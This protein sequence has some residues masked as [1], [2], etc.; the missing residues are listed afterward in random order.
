VFDHQKLIEALQRELVALQSRM[1]D[2][3]DPVANEKP[4]HY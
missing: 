4:P 3:G 2:L 1:H